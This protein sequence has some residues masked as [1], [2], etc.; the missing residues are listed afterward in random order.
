MAVSNTPEDVAARDDAHLRSLGI[1]PELRRTLGFLA[2]FAL[3]FSFIS[4][5]TGSYGNFGV[6]IGLGGP[7][8]FWSWFLVIGGQFLVALVFAE[9]ASHYPVAGSIYQ[10]SKRL[11]NRGLG[12]FTGWFYFWA[13]VVTVSAVAVIVAFAID[14]FVQQPGFLDSP[15]PTGLTTMF[16]FIAIT[17]L[18]V[19]TFVNAFGVRLLSILNN[20]GVGTEI[21]GML[22]FAVILL[23]LANNQPVDV[24]LSFG[25]AEAAQNGNLP[26]TFALGMFMAMFVVY[27]FDTAGTFGEET[28]D[29][30]RHAPRGVLSS[31][32]VSGAIGA[33]FLLAIILS[34]QSIPDAMVEYETGASPIATT[35]L[36]N[37]N[38]ELVAGIT[39]G[40][41]YILVILV[42]VFVC[43][44]AIQGAA[45]RLMFS[46]G[47]DRHLPL[48]GV[49][50]RVNHT[51]K[52][53]ANAAIAVG[54][55]AALPILVT[56]PFGGFVL[57]ICATGLIYLS[58]F[59]C[60]L[61][62]LNARRGGWPRQPAWFNLGR[63]GM[64]VNILALIYGGVM[65]L[66]IALWNDPALFG[67]FGGE[68]RGY[69]N[70]LIN[71]FLQ[72]FGQPLEGLPAWPLY[73]T[74]V[75]TLLLLGAVYYVI[76]I[77]GRRQDVEVDPATGEAVIG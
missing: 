6:A 63:W 73:E 43:T 38:Q 32:L 29:A 64:P 7:V 9:L 19:T 37:L 34:L 51:F 55:L 45:T 21:L 31:V 69:W 50:G 10:W 54:V 49:W 39:L 48:G 18:V 36:G 3:A 70:P 62:V 60:N 68:G 65:I 24:L 26:A 72:W 42:S 8:M 77:R 76:A 16:T 17:T 5:S 25:G 40:E 71:S 57:S 4:V 52:T 33:V 35:I 41:L 66:N 13:Q 30:S 58:Y 2:N 75:A 22:V 47:R 15:D 27:G 1:K 67:D 11:S 61:G 74:V 44:L 20:I 14:G 46:M 53:P 12:W 28:V 59:L 56:G 23:I